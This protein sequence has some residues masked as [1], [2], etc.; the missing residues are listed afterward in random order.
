MLN[1]IDEHSRECLLIRAERRWSSAKVIEALADV[2][3]MKVSRNIYV[4]TMD[5]SPW[6]RSPQMA[7]GH[8]R[9]DCLHRA[10]LALGKR[11][12]RELELE[13]VRR[14]PPCRTLLLD[15]GDPCAG[16]A[17]ARPRQYRS[18]SLLAR[19]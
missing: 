14:V 7:G 17:L 18:A 16:R 13:A 6:L 3:V 10:G 1:L 5:Q 15:Q 4:L 19:L 11:L 9:E 8:R 12:L 2:T